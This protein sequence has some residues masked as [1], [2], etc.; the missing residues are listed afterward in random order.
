MYIYDTAPLVS[1]TRLSI[2]SVSIPYGQR[3][4]TVNIANQ[5]DLVFVAPGNL[6]LR[7]QVDQYTNLDGTSAKGSI[8]SHRCFVT[9]EAVVVSQSILVAATTIP[10]ISLYINNIFVNP[11]IH[12]IYIKRIGFSLIRV[13]KTQNIA[14]NTASSLNLLSQLKW[15]VENIFMG[16]RPDFNVAKPVYGDLAVTSGNKNVWRDWHRFTKLNDQSVYIVSKSNAIIANG[17]DSPTGITPANYALNAFRSTSQQV[18]EKLVYPDSV[19][20]V[21]TIRFLAHGIDIYQTINAD[22]FAS[23]QPYTFGGTNINT[24][25]DEGVFL[26]NF[27]LY[28]GTYQPS[29]HINVSRAREFYVEITSSLATTYACTLYIVATCINFLLISDGSAVLR[30]ST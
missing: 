20:T 19:K 30:Y 12:D 21:D 5:D 18:V 16:L 8:V 24:P 23:Y 25:T 17:N 14:I 2:A 29:G 7:L 9:E 3:F 6:K 11:E 4:I 1:A 13:Y 27:C 15:P 10:N 28:P 26:V 22:F